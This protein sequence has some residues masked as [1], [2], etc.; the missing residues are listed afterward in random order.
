MKTWKAA[1]LRALFRIFSS[2]FS[3]CA[4][5]KDSASARLS[6][7]MARKT[8][9]RMTEWQGS[10]RLLLFY[11]HFIRNCCFQGW[12]WVLAWDTNTGK[13][14]IS[15]DK[16]D[17]EVDADQDTRHAGSFMSHDAVIHHG[18]PVLTSQNLKR[19]HF[20]TKVLQIFQIIF[21]FR[22]IW[23]VVF[24]L[25]L[26]HSDE[27]LRKAVKG[28]AGFGLIWEVEFPSKHLHAQQG[29]YDN[30]EEEEQQQAGNGTYRVQKRSHQ[31]TERCPVSRGTQ[32]QSNNSMG[33]SA[34]CVPSNQRTYNSYFKLLLF[35]NDISGELFLCLSKLTSCQHMCTCNVKPWSSRSH[36]DTGLYIMSLLWM[37]I[38]HWWKPSHLVTLSRRSRR[39]QRSTE[40]PMTDMTPTWTRMSS[41]M[42]VDTTKQSK[43]LKRDMK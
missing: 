39:M 28:A 12:S 24:W 29:E 14:T 36:V 40:M 6:T 11:C 23:G 15:T 3:F 25:Y 21:N 9:S 2:A 19:I 30:E 1:N 13:D 7:A 42:P 4:N 43:R 35:L 17:D 31:I 41:I 18:V 20:N 38:H 33:A 27:G 32:H 8:F 26:K 37:T 34:S 10:Q 5:V 16:K 22:I